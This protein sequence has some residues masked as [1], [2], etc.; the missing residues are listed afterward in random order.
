MQGETADVSGY[1][2]AAVAQ[3]YDD[4]LAVESIDASA[5]LATATAVECGIVST[6]T[7]ANSRL[8]KQLEDSSKTLK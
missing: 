8:T 7:E 4:D 3:P 6:L 5:N 1:A 2:S